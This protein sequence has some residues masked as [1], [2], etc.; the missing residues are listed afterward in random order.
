[1]RVISEGHDRLVL[2][3]AQSCN[4]KMDKVLELCE[5]RR[6]ELQ[7]ILEECRAWEQLRLSIEIWIDEGFIYFFLILKNYN[8]HKKK[9]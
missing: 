1:M 6:N 7:T 2:E 5:R 9:F 8:L 4:Q 3:R